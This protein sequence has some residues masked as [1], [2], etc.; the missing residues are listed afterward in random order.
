LGK[1]EAENRSGAKEQGR[2]AHAAFVAN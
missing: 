2:A 1:T